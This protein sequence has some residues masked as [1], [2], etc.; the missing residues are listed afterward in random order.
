MQKPIKTNKILMIIAA[1]ML[2][3]TL[4][5][6]GQ[7]EFLKNVQKAFEGAGG[8][9]SQGKIADGL[10]EALRI[11]AGN[12]V[13]NVSILNGYYGNPEI[14][15]P[16][17][18]K[19]Q[20]FEKTL[21]TIGFGP[22]LDAFAESM[23]RAAEKAAPAAKS[24]FW[25]AV[26]AMTFDDAKKILKGRDNEATLYLKDKTWSGLLDTFKPMVHKAMAD[27]G[28]TR[29]YQEI[30]TRVKSIPIIGESMGLDIDRYVSEKALNGLFVMLEKEE[31]KIRTDPAA[32]VTELLREV[33]GSNE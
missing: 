33:F 27:V 7:D 26:K 28:V 25:D 1:C 21:R 11:G 31:R 15:I 4:S 18:A 22:Q 24:L 30:E 32:R 8:E 9:L 16:L 17:P 5:C 29:Q 10:K 19:V 23:N 13:E 3:T 20:N 6:A 2:F 14:K 12:A